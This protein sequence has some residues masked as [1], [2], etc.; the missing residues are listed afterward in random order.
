[1]KL[2]RAED[3]ALFLLTRWGYSQ[4]KI[5]YIM[6]LPPSTVQH[7]IE[8]GKED[9]LIGW[10]YVGDIQDRMLT[11]GNDVVPYIDHQDCLAWFVC[12]PCGRTRKEIDDFG[13][14][15]TG[16]TPIAAIRA[17]LEIANSNRNWKPPR[18]IPPGHPLHE[19]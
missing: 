17:A 2:T 5:A 10:D 15:G 7:A 16:K 12:L 13:A 3:R 19:F 11:G 18:V 9:W 6:D 4:R 8:R 14:I 1:M